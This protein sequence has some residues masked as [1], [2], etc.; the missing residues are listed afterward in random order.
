MRRYPQAEIDQRVKSLYTRLIAHDSLIN[1]KR[2][3]EGVHKLC[4][5]EVKRRK[6]IE[7]KP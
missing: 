7:D 5:T 2:I 3:A 4:I 1:A 6:Q